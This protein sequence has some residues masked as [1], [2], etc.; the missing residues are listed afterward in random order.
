VL[1]E[2]ALRQQSPRPLR[3]EDLHIIFR[4]VKRL[5][6]TVQSFLNFARLPSPQV[7]PCDLAAIIEQ[8]W[9]AV[10]ARARL[11]RVELKVNVPSEPVIVSVDAGQLTTVLV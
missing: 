1:V 8:A 4:E 7:A 5:E 10:E 6:Q 11:Q 3:E 9:K 2:A